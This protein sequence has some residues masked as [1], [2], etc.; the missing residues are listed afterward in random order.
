MIL[1]IKKA[2]FLG[3]PKN[4]MIS[5]TRICSLVNIYIHNDSVSTVH[6]WLSYRR[7]TCPF[8]CHEKFKNT[9]LISLFFHIFLILTS[10]F[11]LWCVDFIDLVGQWLINATEKFFMAHLIQFHSTYIEDGR[12]HVAHSSEYNPNFSCQTNQYI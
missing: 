12:K 2:F 5:N 8:K 4:I 10:E 11:V 6:L 7:L 3:I 9:A 1:I